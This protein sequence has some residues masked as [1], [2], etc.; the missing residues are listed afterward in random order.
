MN[1]VSAHGKSAMEFLDALAAAYRATGLT[2][3]TAIV[4]AGGAIYPL[5]L[6]EQDDG[7]HMTLGGVGW[8]ALELDPSLE[9]WS[10]AIVEKEGE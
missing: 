5:L 9:P 3:R 2:P 8:I 7:P 10:A 6:R 4:R 1:V